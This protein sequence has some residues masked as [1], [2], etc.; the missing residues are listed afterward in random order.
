[1]S[2]TRSRLEVALLAIPEA[3]ASTIYGML[4]VLASAGRD[5]DLLV[6]GGAG[7]SLIRTTIVSNDGQGFR[8]A[9]RAWIQPD[10]AL[11]EEYR[12]DA[13][14]V[15]EAAIAPDT[16]LDG[17]Y[18]AENA[19]LRACHRDG[20]L[21]ASACTGSLLLAEAGLLDGCAATTHWGFCDALAR[22]YPAVEVHRDRALVAAG[23]GQRIIMAGG[24]TS[25]QDLALYLIARLID[26][27]E[28]MRV[29]KVHLIDWHDI[30]QRPFAALSSIR[31][32]ED[33]VIARCQNWVAQHY[34]EP[35]PVA[36]MMRLSGLGERTFKRRFANATGMAPMA[37]VHTL[38]V[39]EAKQM[40]EA[41]DA[42]V[43]AVAN[44][45]GY[46]DA[47]FFSRLFRRRV[48]LTP[49]QYRR[50]FG[51]LRRA[52]AGPANPNGQPPY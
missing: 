41:G 19:W 2:E 39:E 8:A 29:A 42:S 50:R 45:I 38:R 23:E 9:N 49:A 12:P 13:V 6:G 51:G 43:E 28:A 15:L 48:G 17:R 25:W 47:A 1:M 4:D 5:W 26:V 16:P 31:G 11:N 7:E 3:T 30:G 22:S 27:E 34:E 36:A 40:L 32:G 33:A 14:C 24:G 44:E 52:L 37:Y 18:P 20:V 10:R 35:A 21:I 46:E